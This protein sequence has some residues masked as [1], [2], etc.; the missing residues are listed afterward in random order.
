M[1]DIILPQVDLLTS[2]N[3][4]TNVLVEQG[5]Q[6]NRVNKSLFGS[7]DAETLNGHAASYFA[8]AASLSTTNTN[9]SNLS[10]RVS[11][12][13]GNYLTSEDITDYSGTIA[14][15]EQRITTLESAPKEITRTLLWAHDGSDDISGPHTLNDSLINYEEIEISGIYTPYDSAVQFVSDQKFPIVI[16]PTEELYVIYEVSTASGFRAIMISTDPNTINIST[17]IDPDG[18]S[19]TTLLNFSS[20]YGIKYN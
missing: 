8:P 11:T 13:E 5:G 17:G 18:N 16:P 10:T 19:N 7:S 6:I 12:I 20:I 3:D 14:T 4:N 1:A 2:T 15:L 9:V